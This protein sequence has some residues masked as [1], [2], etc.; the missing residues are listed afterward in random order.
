[1][2]LNVSKD[3]YD[4]ALVRKW[5]NRRSTSSILRRQ[6]DAAR[7]H[8]STISRVTIVD[9]SFQLPTKRSNSSFVLSMRPGFRNERFVVN[10]CFN[11]PN[12]SNPVGDGSPGV[13]GSLPK[14]GPYKPY[15]WKNRMSLGRHAPRLDALLYHKKFPEEYGD[16]KREGFKAKEG[17]PGVTKMISVL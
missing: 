16:S 9:E 7:S 6:A 1:M 11:A 4:I 13:N 10:K 15:L 17:V 5:F 8:G 14:I 12:S 2:G 3:A